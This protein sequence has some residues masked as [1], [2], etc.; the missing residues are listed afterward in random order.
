MKNFRNLVAGIT[1]VASLGMAAAALAQTPPTPPVPGTGF[2][3][4]G[5]GHPAMDHPGMGPMGAMPG[6]KGP[7]GSFDPTA[8]LEARMAY[9]KSALKITAAQEPAWNKYS[10][11]VKAQA[12]KMKAARTTAVQAAPTS[13]PDK[14][15]YHMDQMGTHLIDMKSFVSNEVKPFY[16]Q[17]TAE[18]KT[19]ADKVLGRP[20]PRM[21]R[22]AQ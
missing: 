20:H 6:A 1:T 12:A 13:A 8:M 15:L 18:Q 3:P 4:P 5:V 19:I 21:G 2:G 17:L 14:M 11:A 10:A 16:D 9:V 7:G 22:P